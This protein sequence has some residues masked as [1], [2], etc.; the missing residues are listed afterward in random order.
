MS[1]RDKSKISFSELDRRRREK[2]RNG[3]DRRPRGEQAEKRTRAASSAYRKRIDEKLFGRRGDAG[4]SRREDRLR[5]A[6]G[7]PAFLRTF[8]EYVKDF[9]MPD[10]V[11]L[12]VSLLDLNEERD[13][14]RVIQALDSSLGEASVDHRNLLRRRLQNLEMTTDSDAL[15]DAAVGLLA[16]I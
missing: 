1:D 12:L 14:L 6:H 9:G 16:R 2:K 4:R 10:D 11:P 3:G 15:A 8:R 7:S 5:E 13:L